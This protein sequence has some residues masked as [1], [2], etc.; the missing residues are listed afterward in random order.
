VNKVSNTR[1][2][3]LIDTLEA[4][5]AERMAVNYANALQRKTG[6]GALVA[7]RGEGAMKNQLEEKVVYSFLKRK[8][9]LDFKA[10]WRLR[11][12]VVLN[13]ITHI[14][15]HSS[16]VFFSVLLKILLPRIYIIW[17]DHY[18]KSEMLGQRPTLA[19]RMASLFM[20]QI[21]AVNYKLKDWATEKLWC[22][23]VKY[24]PN[25]T[26]VNL[27]SNVE[28]T[29]LKGEVGKRIVCLANLRPQ[30]NHMMLLKVAKAIKE[31]HPD[32]TFHLVGKDFNDDYSKSLKDE[33]KRLELTQSV[34]LY[35][36]REDIPNILNQS[37]IG[38]L[39]SSSEG[40]PIA[41]LEYGF[42]NLP[43]VATSVGEIPTVIGEEEGI[44]VTSN[45]VNDFVLTLEKTMNDPKLQNRLATNL[46]LKIV[47]NY[48][49]SAVIEFYLKGIYENK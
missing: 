3:Q 16:S 22:K 21:I 14:H 20:N 38:I 32:W 2:L 39:T 46:H 49:E 36:S 31:S 40:L 15:A 24:L 13:K 1:I 34:F 6:F 26:S 37:T 42:Y 35:G 30:K 10:L 25:F 28:A 7:T 43:I 23:N 45:S 18:G 5:G 17:H 27:D 44:L 41:I 12:F 47:K 9:T 8:S 4:G 48:S 11:E 19:L 33:I 29:I